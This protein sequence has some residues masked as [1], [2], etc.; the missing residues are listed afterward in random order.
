MGK[1]GRALGG[2]EGGTRVR[3]GRAGGDT[4]AWSRVAGTR[5]VGSSEAWKCRAGRE[6]KE[7]GDK[8]RG[9]KAAMDRGAMDGGVGDRQQ[10][11][12]VDTGEVSAGME[13][14]PAAGTA[15]SARV[16]AGRAAASTG[17]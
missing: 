2:M 17:W 9:D 8:L 7:V 12:L 6:G 14:E 13:E 15:G 1:V 3:T 11:I 5:A 10:P 4:E 16:V